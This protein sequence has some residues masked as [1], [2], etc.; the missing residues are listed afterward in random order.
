METKTCKYCQTEIPKKAKICPNCK[1]KQGPKIGLIIIIVIILIAI[2]G[3]AS[4]GDSDNSSSTDNKQTS[5]QNMNKEDN[6]KEDSKK[7][8]KEEESV[9]ID[10]VKVKVSDLIDVLQSNALKASDSYKNTYLEISGYLDV[11]DSSGDYISINAGDNDWS[12]V[13]VQCFIKN[14]DQKAVIMDMNKGDSI[15][16]KGKCTDVGELLGYSINI[17]EVIAK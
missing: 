12:M 17:D 3:A 6:K 13:N 2:I 7:E 5:N 14:D 1:K 9:E 10:Y 15:V 16:I 8:D 4:G 11:I